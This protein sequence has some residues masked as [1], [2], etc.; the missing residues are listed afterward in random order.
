ME[1]YQLPRH[2]IIN[3][4]FFVDIDPKRLSRQGLNHADLTAIINQERAATRAGG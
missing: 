1:L 4:W 2:D 3:W